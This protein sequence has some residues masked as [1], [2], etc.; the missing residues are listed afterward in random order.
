MG[1]RRHFPPTR[2]RKRL[3]KWRLS[4]R[5]PHRST[6]IKRRRS[7]PKPGLRSLR[8]KTLLSGRR[9]RKRRRKRRTARR[10]VQNKVVQRL[11]T[12][13]CL[14]HRLKR[15]KSINR[16]LLHRSHKRRLPR[17]LSMSKLLRV[18]FNLRTKER[19]NKRPLPSWLSQKRQVDV[20]Q[21]LLVSHSAFKREKSVTKTRRLSCSPQRRPRRLTP[22]TTRLR[23]RLKR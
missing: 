16:T 5:F 1:R 21:D 14:R 19:K 2:W 17:P 6:K 13:V 12:T 3:K 4:M 18:T 9:K 7:I 8:H 23:L 10:F 11:P 20:Q 22:I 15:W